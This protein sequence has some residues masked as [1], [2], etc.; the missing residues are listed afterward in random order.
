M[1]SRS[2]TKR[3]TAGT[4]E[5]YTSGTF[6]GLKI[7]DTF[8]DNTDL[9]KSITCTPDI[10]LI[11]NNTKA[12]FDFSHCDFTNE[13]DQTSVVFDGLTL[14]DGI[15]VSNGYHIDD[16]T[17]E[18]SNLSG[19]YTVTGK[20]TDT[21]IADV[22]SLNQAQDYDKKYKKENFTDEFTFVT[23]ASSVDTSS[24]YMIKN[25]FNTLGSE[26]FLRLGIRIDDKIRFNNGTNSGNLYDIISIYVD[27][28][29]HEIIGIT[30]SSSGYSVSEENRF[31]Q[32]TSF[33]LFRIDSEESV[34]T[35][36]LI[37]DPLNQMFFFSPQLDLTLRKYKFSDYY[38]PTLN[39]KTNNTYVFNILGVSNNFSISTTPDGTWN[40]GVE[41]AGLIKYK[42]ALLFHPESSD[43]FYYF[44]KKI[45]NAGGEI[46]VTSN[47]NFYTTT[48]SIT[49]QTSYINSEV[50][51]RINA[52]KQSIQDI[53]I[54][55]LSDVNF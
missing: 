55:T 45:R 44:D 16:E 46:K 37:A 30:A 13:F 26:S 11:E 22:V 19:Y 6:H 14:S 27:E 49:S 24:K 42:N 17:Y 4:P 8:N 10:T 1:S 9:D 18:E 52:V 54:I 41:Y 39:L 20:Y 34:T 25:Y 40:G 50:S 47:V 23:S 31:N 7:F 38:V 21:I 48:D 53:S 2:N 36:S 51:S 32:E 29:D 43:T 12:I 3:R 15:T 5:Y 35:A 33:D 28:N